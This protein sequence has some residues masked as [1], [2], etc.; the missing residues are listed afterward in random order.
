M[1]D[2]R[3]NNPG[4]SPLVQFLL[5]NIQETREPDLNYEPVKM[6]RLRAVSRKLIQYT[7]ICWK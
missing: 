6:Q 1:A 4:L 3:A 2:E 7:I 5:K